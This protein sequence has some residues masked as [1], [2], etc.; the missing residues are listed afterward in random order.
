M[1]HV[2]DEAFLLTGQGRRCTF[3]RRSY[4]DFVGGLLDGTERPQ[5][6]RCVIEP[7][8]SYRSI[9]TN[10]SLRGS[11]LRWTKEEAWLRRVP[12][13]RSVANA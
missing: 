12:T 9:P 2:V 11:L 13:E 6:L 3:E 5:S 10:P 8:H 7:G 4:I 1:S